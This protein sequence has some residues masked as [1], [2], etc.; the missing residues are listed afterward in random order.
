[1]EQIRVLL[2]DD[3]AAFRAGLAAL[4]KPVIGIQIADEAS[5]G[6]QALALVGQVQP[7]SS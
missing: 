5:S 3:H 7:T 1:M 4:L 2:V 6:E